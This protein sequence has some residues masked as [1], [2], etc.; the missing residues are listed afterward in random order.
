[1]VRKI[2]L[3]YSI[4]TDPYIFSKK[5]FDENTYDLFITDLCKFIEENMKFFE[6]DS[7]RYIELSEY[8]CLIK[9]EKEN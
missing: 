1:M 3:N 5:V 7:H 4:S 2:T 6:E 9:S 8:L